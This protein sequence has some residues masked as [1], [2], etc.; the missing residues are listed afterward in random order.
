MDTLET[1]LETALSKLGEPVPSHELRAMRLLT[2]LDLDIARAHE[3]RD[4]PVLALLDKDDWDD[5]S[6]SSF[7]QSRTLFRHGVIL[8]PALSAQ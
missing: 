8:R 7:C 1:A 2:A 6:A 3:A 4:V 5:L